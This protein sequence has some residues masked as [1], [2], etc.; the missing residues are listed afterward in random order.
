[1]KKILVTG[2]SGL[3][4]TSLSDFLTQEGH[5]ISWLSR[6]SKPTNYQSFLWNPTASE[7]DYAALKNKDVL[8]QLAGINIAGG[9]WTTKRKKV[10]IDSRVKAIETLY[11]HLKKHQLRIP[12]II[13]ASAIGFYGNRGLEVINEDSTAG[14]EGF[15]TEVCKIWESEASCLKEFTDC[16]SIIRTG[17]Y[18]SPKGGIWPKMIQTKCF[19]FLVSFGDGSQYYS[20]IHH[21]D[22][23]GAI[24]KIINQ[25]LRG[26]INLTAPNPVSNKDF[27][28]EI[29]H[30]L[31]R[32]VFQ[33]SVPAF[34]LKLL[35]G[36][37]SQSVLSSAFVM[38]QV[39]IDNGYAFQFGK[40]DLAIK[41]LMTKDHEIQL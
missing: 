41:N 17:L 31:S 11:H 15:L 23:N 20:W 38:P 34:A 5:H 16:L 18:L 8:I 29:N 19:G 1:M 25:Q 4:G 30:Q 14:K 28:S 22:Y 3:I 24:S 35:L 33:F 6:N 26:I 7:M 37:L 10:I 21:L 27:I 2:G 12:H 13:Q 9:L 36:E 39:L 40:L 32:K